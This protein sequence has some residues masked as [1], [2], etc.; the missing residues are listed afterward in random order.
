[1]GREPGKPNFLWVDYKNAIALHQV[2]KG[3]PKDHRLQRLAS[4]TP[5]DNRISFGCINVPVDF[6]Q[7]TVLPALKGAKAVVYIL[8]EIKPTRSFFPH[9]YDVIE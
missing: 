9:Y 7:R 2:V 4:P 8:P 6:F 5:L 1:M 3:V